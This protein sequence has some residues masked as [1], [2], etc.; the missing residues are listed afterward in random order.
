MDWK[1][2]IAYIAQL[3]YFQGAVVAHQID[4]LYIPKLLLELDDFRSTLKR[5]YK[6]KE[7]K[8]NILLLIFPPLLIKLYTARPDH[9]ALL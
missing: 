3:F 8:V 1:E 6:W 4:S 5:L 2:R 9:Q 7:H